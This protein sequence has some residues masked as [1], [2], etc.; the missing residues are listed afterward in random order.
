M[1]DGRIIVNSLGIALTMLGV[2]VVY[3]NSPSTT[4][5]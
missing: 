1:V 4:Q 5:S 2:Y 3:I